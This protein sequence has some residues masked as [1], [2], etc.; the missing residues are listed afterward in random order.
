MRQ[1]SFSDLAS[2]IQSAALGAA[3][4]QSKGLS[5]HMQ[6]PKGYREPVGYLSDIIGGMPGL[7]SI[8]AHQTR[9]A[10]CSKIIAFS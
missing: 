9:V 5:P 8:I 2:R 3:P 1:P 6:N 7:T 4:K 10:T